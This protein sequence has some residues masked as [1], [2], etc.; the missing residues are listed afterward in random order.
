MLPRFAAV[1]TAHSPGGMMF[2]PVPMGVG[3]MRPRAPY[4][5][6]SPRS[7][8]SWCCAPPPLPPAVGYHRQCPGVARTET[9]RRRRNA[10]RLEMFPKCDASESST[11]SASD[12]SS[13]SSSSV[14]ASSSSDSSPAPEP[15]AVISTSS[16]SPGVGLGA[17]SGKNSR[18]VSRSVL[19]KAAHAS[20]EPGL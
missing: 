7:P 5:S 10:Q 12:D 1:S 19:Q 2:G 20:S 6:C 3:S 14:L 17:W 16:S 18:S 13:P 9:S 11:N 15:V 4:V 8:L